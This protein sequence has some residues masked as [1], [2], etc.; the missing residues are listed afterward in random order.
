MGSIV[1]Y[2]ITVMWDESGAG[3][4]GT[5]CDPDD[6]NDLKCFTTSFQVTP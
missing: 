1:P 5:G 4:T 3:V 2:V 6:G